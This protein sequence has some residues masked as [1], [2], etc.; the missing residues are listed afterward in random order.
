MG[1]EASL[2]CLPS[3]FQKVIQK[4]KQEIEPIVE[5]CILAKKIQ[6]CAILNL[7]VVP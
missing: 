7:L 5:L 3:S 2:K 6:S 1:L 4:K